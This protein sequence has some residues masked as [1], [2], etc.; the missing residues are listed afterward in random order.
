MET[1]SLTRTGNT[2][3]TFTG[4]QIAAEE[5]KHH[6]GREQTRW[7]N[8][9]L[10]KTTGGAIVLQ[11]Q[12]CTLYQ[13]ELG[14]ED[15]WIL[16]PSDRKLLSAWLG[17]KLSSYC[18]EIEGRLRGFPAGEAYAKKQARLLQDVKERYLERVSDLLAALPEA[19][20]MVE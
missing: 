6:A 8:L 5:G 1:Y 13:G 17:W 10:Y 14:R 19:A 16:P 9:Y 12:F 20:E 15:A 2:P 3:L 11:V 7:H 18:Y 4:E